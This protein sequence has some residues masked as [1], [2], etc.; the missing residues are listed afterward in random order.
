MLSRPAAKL[1]TMIALVAASSITAA[2]E[3]APVADP[4]PQ[5]DPDRVYALDAAL[6]RILQ[7]FS[8]PGLAVG[9]V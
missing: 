7:E 9:I 1:L 4:L 6:E 8:I 5:L 3:G 2:Q